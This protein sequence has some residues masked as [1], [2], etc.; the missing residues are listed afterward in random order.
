VSIKWKIP[1][2]R[3]FTGDIPASQVWSG[4]R[5]SLSSVDDLLL[6]WKLEPEVFRQ[7]RRRLEEGRRDV[8]GSTGSSLDQRLMN[9]AKSDL[10][11]AIHYAEDKHLM[12]FAPTGSGKGVSVIIPNLL[13]YGGPA[14]V[15]D[16][17]GEN[18]SV[19][20][21]YR[22]Q[23]LGHE[24]HLL[25]PFRSV[26]EKEMERAGV[27]RG[28][29]DP[30]DLWKVSTT[31]TTN[32]AQMLAEILGGEATN[33]QNPFWD[34]QGRKIISGVIAHRL[35]R[36]KVTNVAPSF[37]DVVNDIYSADFEER[38]R[39]LYNTEQPTG[40]V[41]RTLVGG[42]TS[43][44]ADETRAGMLSTAQSYLSLFVSK[45]IQNSLKDST[46]DLPSIQRA[47]RSTIYIVVPPDKLK[48]HSRLLKLWIGV[49]M[50]TIMSR[51]SRPNERTLFILDE[52]ANL[53][54]LEALETAVTLLR[55]YGL[56]VWMFFQDLSQ[57]TSLYRGASPTMINNCGV[58]QTFGLTRL[59]QAQELAAI[60]GKFDAGELLRLDQTQQALSVGKTVQ[61]GEL[62]RYF[63]DAAFSGRFDPNHLHAGL[64]R[65]KPSF[66]DFLKTRL[67]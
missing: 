40:F 9:E 54:Y 19:T 47:D 14:I 26:G 21:R 18:F 17:K 25:D 29:L 31:D 43:I 3:G 5:R 11:S 4:T 63:S 13:H 34:L 57:V 46:I 49:L 67:Q 61:S 50:H 8:L 39:A 23:V 37:T 41:E 52:C 64:D 59:S 65:R 32:D 36:R 53:G 2:P 15:I 27:Q 48:S 12:T 30:L 16:P 24:I 58:V 45:E 38:I 22:K 66:A 56:Q 35:E 7:R 6:G 44:S 33:S 55:G 10:S 28:R 51:K 60:L 1:D 20:A 62:F 42:F